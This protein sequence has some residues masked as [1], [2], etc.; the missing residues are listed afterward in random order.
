MW[1]HLAPFVRQQVY[2]IQVSCKCHYNTFPHFSTAPNQAVA[3]YWTTGLHRQPTTVVLLPFRD[4]WLPNRYR[5]G[6][7]GV[8]MT[9]RDVSFQMSRLR[10]DLGL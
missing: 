3:T 1:L 8:Q 4:L 10:P 6:Q 9:D 5:Q 2:I 7:E